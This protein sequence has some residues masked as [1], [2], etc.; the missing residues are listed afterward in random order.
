MA[1]IKLVKKIPDEPIKNENMEQIITDEKCP[2]CGR[3]LKINILKNIPPEFS[4]RRRQKCKCL[5]LENKKNNERLKKDDENRKIKR[6]FNQ[7]N[8]GERFEKSNFESIIKTEHNKILLGTLEKFANEF[9]KHKEKSFLIFSHVGT[10]KTLMTSATCNLIMQKHNNSCI[11][12]RITD[13][14]NQIQETYSKDSTIKESKIMYNLKRCS[15]LVL[16]D[17]G[18]ETLTEKAEEII[19]KIID[20]RYNNSKSIILT[21]N[22]TLEGLKTRYHTRILSRIMDMTNWGGRFSLENEKDFRQENK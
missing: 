22:L 17:L 4:P 11:F 16:D 9:P 20:D 18:T 13:L 2:K 21:A 12:M 1:D 7:S 5:L 15:L 6:L 10:G 8:L 19:Y 3:F 14:I